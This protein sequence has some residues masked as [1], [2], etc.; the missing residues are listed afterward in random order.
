MLTLLLTHTT[1]LSGS[2][3]E[4]MERCLA[5][6]AHGDTGALGRL[7]ELTREAVYGYALSILKNAHDAEDVM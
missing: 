3:A 7:N 2:G 6:M 4:E 1:P 5:R